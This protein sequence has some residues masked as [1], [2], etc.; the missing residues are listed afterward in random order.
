MCKQKVLKRM[1]NECQ[2]V[3]GHWKKYSVNYVANVMTLN[4]KRALKL[5][6][7]EALKLSRI[8]DRIF[9]PHI[10]ENPTSLV[11]QYSYVLYEVDETTTEDHA[12]YPGVTP[13]ETIMLYWTYGINIYKYKPIGPVMIKFHRESDYIL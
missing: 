2:L 11:E 8:M 9:V 7:K 5:C 4:K 6:L 1:F 13:W 3:E 10:N 12:Q